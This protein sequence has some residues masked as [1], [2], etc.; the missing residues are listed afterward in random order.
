METLVFCP[1]K[2]L[3]ELDGSVLRVF[4]ILNFRRGNVF[5]LS[6]YYQ[7]LEQEWRSAQ[8]R[9]HSFLFLLFT[10]FHLAVTL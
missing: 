1:V 10:S 7:K 9:L 4:L 6:L 5:F 8:L 3:P 2:H